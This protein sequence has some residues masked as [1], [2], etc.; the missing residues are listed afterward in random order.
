[1][2]ALDAATGD[3]LW[4]YA[5]G[6][7]SNGITSSPVVGGDGV[8]PADIALYFGGGDGL[9]YSLNL[10]GTPRWNSDVGDIIYYSTPLVHD[11][12]VFIGDDGGPMPDDDIS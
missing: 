4:Q 3:I 11:G 12:K 1:M 7:S 10:N 9:V 5:T 8:S 6:N 2:Y